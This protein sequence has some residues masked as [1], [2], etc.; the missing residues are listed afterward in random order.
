MQSM[1][2]ILVQDDEIRPEADEARLATAQM[3]YKDIRIDSAEDV[4]SKKSEAINSATMKTEEI[5]RIK[6][7]I[8]VGSKVA[9]SNGSTPHNSH[10]PMT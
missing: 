2:E 5:E 3:A 7:G 8:S 6:A 4:P 1:N 9:V 10:R